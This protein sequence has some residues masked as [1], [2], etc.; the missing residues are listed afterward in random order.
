[1]IPGNTLQVYKRIQPFLPNFIYSRPAKTVTKA[2]NIAESFT[3]FSYRWMVLG[4]GCFIVNTLHQIHFDKIHYI[5]YILIEFVQLFF[6]FIFPIVFLLDCSSKFW[7]PHG[8]G[9][10]VNNLITYLQFY[11]LTT[12]QLVIGSYCKEDSNFYAWQSLPV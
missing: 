2:S 3:L 9:F 8:L 1:M 11:I 10:C 12:I 7:L 6:D 5:K 4:F